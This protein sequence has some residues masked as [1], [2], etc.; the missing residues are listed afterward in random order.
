[1]SSIK[2]NHDSNH[3]LLSKFAML[4]NFGVVTLS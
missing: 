2:S 1:V 4:E 3:R